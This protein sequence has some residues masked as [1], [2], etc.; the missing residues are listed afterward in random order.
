MAIEKI[1]TRLK[2]AM[3][4]KNV[5]AVELSEATGIPKSA[6]SQYLS[7]YASPKQDRITLISDYLGINEPWLM[8]FNIPMNKSDIKS[9]DEL[10]M[11]INSLDSDHRKQVFD[12]VRFL[13]S[14]QDTD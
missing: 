7:G 2:K 8:G 6:I 11:M 12:Y 1:K 3:E 14:Q 5:K 10:L 13:Y 4:I 9:N